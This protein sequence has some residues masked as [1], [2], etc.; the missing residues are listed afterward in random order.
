MI[1]TEEAWSLPELPGS[2]VVIGAGASGVEVASAYAR[3]GVDV[4]LYEALDRL[5]PTEDADVSKLAARALAKQ[6]V[7]VK[8]GSRYEGQDADWV[9]IAAGRRPDVDALGVDGI[10]LT[11]GGLIEVARCR[12]RG[13]R[14]T[15]SVISFLALRLRTRRQT[16]ASWPSRPRPG[17]RRSRWRTTTSRARAA[18]GWVIHG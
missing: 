16:K 15:R 3:L 14:S 1:G 13:R 4:T 5:L 10:H 7:K 9:V 11:D 18:D 2:M 6:G 8:V 17:V 12:P